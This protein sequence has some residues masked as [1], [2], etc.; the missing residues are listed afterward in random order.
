MFQTRTHDDIVTLTN[1]GGRSTYQ[2]VGATRRQG[3]EL[4]WQAQPFTS[5]HVQAAYTYLD[6][7]YRTTFLTCTT[8]PCPSPNVT[9]PEGNRLPGIARHSL[10]GALDWTP[11]AGVRAGV[12]ARYLSGVYVNDINS[13]AAPGFIVADL[14]AGWTHTVGAWTFSTFA[15]LDN[16]T[17]KRYIGS[18]IVNE[19][20]GRYFEPAPGRSWFA[21]ASLAASF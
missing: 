7:R 10:D 13:D 14:H 1:I 5:W 21:G 3:V 6:A 11:V 19:G 15:R 12:E 9:V 17:D 8:S 18:V 20:N 4:S 2:N 16:V